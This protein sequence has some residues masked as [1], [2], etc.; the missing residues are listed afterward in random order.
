MKGKALG[1]CAL[2]LAVALSCSDPERVFEE[3]VEIPESRWALDQKAVLTVD[4]TDTVH[5]HNFLINVRNTEK[6]PYRNLYVFV[7]TQFPN[8]KSSRDTVGIMLADPSG[9][10]Y[11]SG[12]GFLW[13]GR[14]P[15]ASIM[16]SYNR[17]FP[18][19]GSYTFEIQHA[20]RTD[21][22]AGIRSIG[23]RVE[24]TH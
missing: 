15:G 9:K 10:W 20:M 8:G 12:N 14:Y 23:L 4:I 17:R 6:Y 1:I 24:K 19:Q 5:P 22:L 21:T 13:S 7:K 11:G 18:L 2:L 16:Y 3:N